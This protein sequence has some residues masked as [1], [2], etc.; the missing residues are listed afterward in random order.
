FQRSP[1]SA[2]ITVLHRIF[3]SESIGA[4]REKAT[5]LGISAQEWMH[6]L[7]W[8][9]ARLTIGGWVF[10]PIIFRP[11]LRKLVAATEAASI[12]PELITMYD[13]DFVYSAESDFNEELLTEMCGFDHAIVNEKLT[14]SFSTMTQ[15]AELF[16]KR[17]PWDRSYDRKKAL[18]SLAVLD[19]FFMIGSS[20]LGYYDGKGQLNI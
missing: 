14:S 5:V 8:A 16:V 15:K 6:F 11:K 10:R 4:L 18:P 7:H 20:K 17:L 9:S 13:E 12:Y 19:V 3:A 1:K 2:A